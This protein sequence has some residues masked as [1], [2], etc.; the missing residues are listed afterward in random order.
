[1]R[2]PKL[3]F[4][5][6][7]ILG[8]LLTSQSVR[9]PD[10]S[11]EF[12][13]H[14]F[15]GEGLKPTAEK[16]KAVQECGKQESKEEVRS[17]LG[18]VGYLSKFIPE[19]TSITAPLREVTHKDIHLKWGKEQ[20]EAFETLKGSITN[21][22][23]MAYF[24]PDLPIIVR[25]EASY[26]QGRSAGLFQETVNGLQPVH[27]ISRTLTDTEQR[28]SQTEKDALAIKWAKHRFSMYL[29]GA[30]KFRIIT[31]HKQLIPMF[32]KA[33]SQLPP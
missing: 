22:S 15:T 11:V 12:Y 20:E 1:M 10:S 9:F 29:L 32:S 7:L 16:V 21:S 28:Y 31:S 33:T 18:M 13:G 4:R 5:E 30:P 26:S 23:T 27:Y 8:L 24:R 19:Y 3:F 25:T 2:H 6:S 17:F 14:Q